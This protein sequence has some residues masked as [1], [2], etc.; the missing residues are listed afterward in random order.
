MS[1]FVRK[2]IFLL[3]SSYEKA[4]FENA[5]LLKALKNLTETAEDT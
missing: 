5:I 3:I 2:F 1:E 4:V